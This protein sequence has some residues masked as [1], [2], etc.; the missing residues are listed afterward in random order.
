MRFELVGQF[1]VVICYCLLQNSQTTPELKREIESTIEREMCA[2]LMQNFSK[3]LE[4]CRHSQGAYVNDI[5]F[6]SKWYSVL[7]ILFK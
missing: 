7:Y 2:K 5:L 3:R 1:F 4:Y 6:K